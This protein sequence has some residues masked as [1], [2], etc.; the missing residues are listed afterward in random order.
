M[1]FPKA[2]KDLLMFAPSCNLRPQL[3]VT[4]AHSDP[5]RS[6]RANL[7][8]LISTSTPA[9]LSLC[10]TVTNRIAWDQELV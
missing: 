5:A 6:I 2:S 1:Q 7:L 10:S 4:E 9:S 3:F 8:Y